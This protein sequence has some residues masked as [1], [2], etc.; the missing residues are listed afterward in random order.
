MVNLIDAVIAKE[1]RE[2]SFEYKLDPDSSGFA[3]SPAGNKPSKM[4]IESTLSV[5]DARL[6]RVPKLEPDFFR[7]L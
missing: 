1:I 6:F 7:L 4:V 5:F 3:P 2:V